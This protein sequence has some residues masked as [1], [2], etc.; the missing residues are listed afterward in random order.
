MNFAATRKS[1][2]NDLETSARIKPFG[3]SLCE[4]S[5]IATEAPV[6]WRSAM[7]PPRLRTN[8]VLR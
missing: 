5:V 4:I 2:L 6:I 7:S 3:A 8:K 1:C